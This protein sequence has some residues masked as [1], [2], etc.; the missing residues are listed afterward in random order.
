MI[1][2][3]AFIFGTVMHLY[4]GYSQ[5]RYYTSI[6]NILKV[7]NFLKKFTFCTFWL[8]GKHSKDTKFI[9][10]IPHTDTCTYTDTGTHRQ[11]PF[12]HFTNLIFGT[13]HRHMH[14]QR[15]RYHFYILHSLVYMPKIFGIPQ[16]CTC[17]DTHT[18]THLE[19]P[20]TRQEDRK[21]KEIVTPRP[22]LSCNKQKS[23]L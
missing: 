9:S 6:N 16:T 12:L 15:H 18:C 2:L 22:H 7:I 14:T 23:L 11:I 13:P 17:T 21:F 4:W 10:G 19:N 8:I 5:G 20:Y 3:R 1:K